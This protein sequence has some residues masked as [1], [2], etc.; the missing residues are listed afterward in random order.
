ML[1]NPTFGDAAW[2]GSENT[3]QAWI[4]FHCLSELMLND[5]VNNV[6]VISRKKPTIHDTDF[7]LRAITLEE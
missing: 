5:P 7:V 4:L 2:T 1:N 3:V 6:S